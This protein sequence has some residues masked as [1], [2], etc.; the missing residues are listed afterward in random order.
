[1]QTISSQKSL[2]RLFRQMIFVPCLHNRWLNTQ[3]KDRLDDAIGKAEGGHQGEIC[4][5]IENHLPIAS[6]YHTD[7]HARAVDLFGLHRVWDTQNNTG[8]LIYLNI[9]EHALHI[10]ADRGI[11]DVVEQDT[12][13][14]LCQESLASFKRT[15]FEVGLLTLIDK[16]GQLL[17]NHY[18]TDTVGNEL[19]NRP[20]YLK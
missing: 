17:H 14:T 12:W 9:C 11:N 19:P 18:P 6:A 1:M 4:L 13:Q 2:A 8:V 15:E 3:T 10:I 16:V 5:I 7:T 20:I